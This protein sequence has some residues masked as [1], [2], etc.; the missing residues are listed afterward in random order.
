MVLACGNSLHLTL[1]N[2]FPHNISAA[3]ALMMMCPRTDTHLTYM[4]DIA[5]TTE[6]ALAAGGVR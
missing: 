6:F 1:A 2:A 3:Q 5:L 4:I